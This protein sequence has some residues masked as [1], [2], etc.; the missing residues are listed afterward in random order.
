[1]R[2][3][4]LSLFTEVTSHN[5]LR[6]AAKKQPGTLSKAIRRIEAYYQ[7]ELF[8]RSGKSWQ[9]TAAG[10]QLLARSRELL[11]LHGTIEKE[12]G[13]PRRL[14]IKISGA[15]ILLAHNLPVIIEPLRSRFG[16]FSFE[17]FQDKGLEKLRRNQVDL[18]LVSTIGEP[19]PVAGLTFHKLQDLRFVVVASPLH[20]LVRNRQLKKGEQACGVE[21]V[22][23]YSFVIPSTMIYGDTGS[24]LS[25][26]GWHEEDFPR[27]IG[28]RVDS[29]AALKATI[30]TGHWLAYLPEYLVDKSSMEIVPVS[31][32]SYECVQ[33][34][35]L[36]AQSPVQN[37]WISA[38]MN[39]I[40]NNEA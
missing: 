2:I 13:K 15:A 3:D 6:D 29:F 30:E 25:T 24:P 8:D 9:L 23:E 38:L 21:D 4:D 20:P 26:D 39:E 27:K 22:L 5:G 1:M 10:H 17:T 32:C 35:W 34:I 18:A 31:G 40:E 16:E 33:S 28:A 12:M 19:P 36:C 7:C 14:H 11:A 37:Y